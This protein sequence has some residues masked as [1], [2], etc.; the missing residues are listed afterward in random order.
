VPTHD[1]GRYVVSPPAL[2]HLADQLIGGFLRRI[3]PDD[4]C[5]FIVV[6]HIR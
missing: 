4:F 1:Q 3:A 5:D 6:Q 2:Q